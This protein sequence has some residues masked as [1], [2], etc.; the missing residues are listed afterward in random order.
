M[1]KKKRNSWKM[2]KYII[3]N[4]QKVENCRKMSKKSKHLVIV[5]KVKKSW[6]VVNK[7]KF[8]KHF[9]KFE[10]MW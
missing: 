2:L 8:V 9:D 6:N 3:K 5:Q 1:T 4:S 10:E 7:K